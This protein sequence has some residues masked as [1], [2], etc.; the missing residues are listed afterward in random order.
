MQ[1][2]WHRAAATALLTAVM[3]DWHRR[4]DRR[5]GSALALRHR[6]KG[7]TSRI[8]V[9]T[10]T[11]WRRLAGRRRTV[12]AVEAILEK[13]KCSSKVSQVSFLGWR[14]QVHIEELRRSR[15][16]GHVGARNLG[17]RLVAA[18]AIVA[19]K[20]HI[21]STKAEKAA[22]Q[23]AERLENERRGLEEQL[24]QAYEQADQAVASMQRELRTKE[25]L[26][27]DLREV[28][29]QASRTAGGA[30]AASRGSDLR[31]G[32]T[33]GT[34]AT[35]NEAAAALLGGQSGARSCPGLNQT[36]A[37]SIGSRRRHTSPLAAAAATPELPE[38]YCEEQTVYEA[39][40]APG[41]YAAGGGGG[42]HGLTLDTGMVTRNS[43][44]ANWDS[45]LWR[46]TGDEAL[47][48][49]PGRRTEA[50]R[51]SCNPRGAASPADS[52][53]L[54]RGGA[55]APVFATPPQMTRRNGHY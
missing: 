16:A 28:Y 12:A 14:Q 47:A 33:A 38:Q 34:V 26:A 37:P 52:Q 39:D 54:L 15:I 40:Y 43:K 3:S 8:L 17:S 53:V 44:A 42:R 18:M 21:H 32:G 22:A 10:L 20:A 30:H 23:L 25:L 55:E 50:P 48:P 5:H 19:W 13:R 36:S 29:D 31:H 6:S 1:Q 45:A 49:S 41:D 9:A 7:I 27:A 51:Q 2:R 24:T 35:A 11:D 46:M 4:A